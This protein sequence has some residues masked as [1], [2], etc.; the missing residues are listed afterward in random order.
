MAKMTKTQA[1]RAYL[2]IMQKSR[3]LYLYDSPGMGR[4]GMST[5][6]VIAIEKICDKYLKKF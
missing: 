2:A 6:D 5:T 4:Y 1:K 3:K